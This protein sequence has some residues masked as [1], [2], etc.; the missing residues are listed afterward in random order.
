MVD[1]LRKYSILDAYIYI[2][3]ISPTALYNACTH[4]PPNDL[5]AEKLQLKMSRDAVTHEGKS[6]SQL[7]SNISAKWRLARMQ[8]NRTHIP[9]LAHT[10]H[11]ARNTAAESEDSGDAGWEFAGLIVVR[12]LVVGHGALVEEVIAESDAFVDSK[13]VA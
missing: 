4:L 11:H 7:K 1:S 2:N 5:S 12:G 6:K 9:N 13:P 8:R 10:R 3:G